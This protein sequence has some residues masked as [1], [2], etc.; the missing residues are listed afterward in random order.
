MLL[1]TQDKTFKSALDIVV[2]QLKSRI[3]SAEGTITELVRSLEFSQAE[4]KD[5]QS[6][7][8]VLRNSDCEQKAEIDMLKLKVGELEK[9]ANYQEDY[10]RRNNLRITGVLEKPNE[11]WEE[12]AVSVAKLFE[13]KLQLPSVRL[14][15]AHRTGPAT[16]SRPRTIVARFER[17]GDREAAIR[18]S[19]KLK[20]TGIFINEDLCPMSQEI[21]KSQ[22]PLMKKAREEGKIAFFKHT[23]L[24]IKERTSGRPGLGH[25]GSSASSGGGDVMVVPRPGWGAVGAGGGAVAGAGCGRDTPAAARGGVGLAASSAVAAAAAASSGPAAG[26]GAAGDDAASALDPVVPP[27]GALVASPAAVGDDG[28]KASAPGGMQ[29]PSAAGEGLAAGASQLT[30]KSLRNR[31]PR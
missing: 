16:P 20:G 12:T 22:F 17:F 31:K 29:D 9:R 3:Q 11:T 1:E 23:R 19:R 5:L 4:L 27:A 13:E 30:K 2:D 7:L 18:N 10:N 14:E 6:E 24:V 21:K 26:A 28:G 8:R 15:R 25:A